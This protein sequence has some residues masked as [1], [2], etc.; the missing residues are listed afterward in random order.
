MTS[1]EFL[2]IHDFEKYRPLIEA[3][4]LPPLLGDK[5]FYARSEL[6]NEKFFL[7]SE[8]KLSAF[9]APFDYT[10]L[11]ARVVLIGLT[12]GWT[13]MER[14]F[15]VAKRALTSGL[16]GEELLAYV[17][18]SASFSGPMRKNLVSMLDGINV[19]QH[20]KVSS[21]ADL[22]GSASALVHFTSA[23]SVPTFVDGANFSGHGAS[24]LKL[25]KFRQFMID[26]LAQ[27]LELLPDAIV[28]PLGKIVDEILEFLRGETLINPARCLTG[29]PHPSGQNGHRKVFYERG[30]RHWN[31]QLAGW[32]A[33][34]SSA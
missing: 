3:L 27:E 32:F 29:F 4:N 9:Y 2:L 31:D 16:T 7:F 20:L 18:K 6:I 28:V 1:H 26:N 14:A 5:A 24:P 15:R 11:K 33:S 8:G 34:H 17:K 12:P 25:P 22:F 21:C 19:N 10:N 23:I 13:Q 30:K